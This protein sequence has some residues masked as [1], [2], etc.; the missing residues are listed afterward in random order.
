MENQFDDFRREIRQLYEE[1]ERL[2][3]EIV[4]AE[5]RGFDKAM[6]SKK[7]SDDANRAIEIYKDTIKKLLGEQEKAAQTGK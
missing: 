1:I 4:L 6:E 2:K 5:K 3:S 7:I